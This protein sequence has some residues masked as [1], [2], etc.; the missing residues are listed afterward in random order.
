MSGRLKLKTMKKPEKICCVTGKN[1]V[2]EFDDG[3]FW[4]Q[5]FVMGACEYV[6]EDSDMLKLCIEAGYK[7][8]QEAYDDGFYYYTEWEHDDLISEIEE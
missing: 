3:T 6:L 2:Q 8:M 4:A 7:T 1:L 5:G